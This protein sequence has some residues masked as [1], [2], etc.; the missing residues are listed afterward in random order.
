VNTRPAAS[1]GTTPK[2]TGRERRKEAR[3]SVRL[4][5]QIQGFDV[6][7]MAWDEMT[8]TDDVS[9]GG[10]SFQLRHAVAL[11]QAVHL[12]LPMPK[13]FRRYD[14]TTPSY[15]V[16]AIARKVEPVAVG[17]RVG[18]MFL[19]RNAPQGFASANERF[20]LAGD[21]PPEPERRTLPRFPLAMQL[22]V[23][24]QLCGAGTPAEEFALTENVSLEGALLLTTLP[25]MKGETVELEEIG[26]GFRSLA[27]VEKIIIGR[28]N[29][30]RLSLRFTSP[31]AAGQAREALRHAGFVDPWTMTG[32]R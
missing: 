30:P 16:Y 32:P 29:L 3:M 18:V 23:R 19:G 21:R 4:P 7:G 12:S 2:S 26:G 22:R 11:G 9:F 5:V 24:R 14:L 28:D 10:V 15:R 20:L 1:V 6:D 31:H 13:R 27:E 25:I 17:Q 8:S